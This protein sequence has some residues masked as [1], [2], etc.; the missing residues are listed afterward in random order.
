MEDEEIKC[1]LQECDLCHEYFDIQQIRITE[2]G[3][4]VLCDKCIAEPSIRS[5]IS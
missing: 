3:R 2:T 5:D 1:F 4:Q